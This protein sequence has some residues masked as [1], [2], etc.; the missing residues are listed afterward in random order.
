MPFVIRAR[1]VAQPALRPARCVALAFLVACDATTVL[2]PDDIPADARIVA[3][4]PAST[5]APSGPWSDERPTIRMRT[6]AGAAVANRLVE[7]K[8]VGPDGAFRTFAVRTDSAGRGMLPSI[9]LDSVGAWRVEVRAGMA[10]PLQFGVIA[11][12]RALMATARAA[13]CPLAPDQLP[14]FA[15]LPRSAALLRA[16]RP[17]RIVALGT[18]S[19]SGYGLDNWSNAYPYAF[20]EQLRAVF[21][22]SDVLLWNRGSAGYA[23]ERIDSRLEID[24]FSVN[25]DL[26]LLQTGMMDAI[27]GVPLN[28]LRTVTERTIDR[29]Q[30][31]GIDVVLIDQQRTPGTGE[32]E[33]YLRYVDLIGRI[34]EE[35]GLPLVRRYEWMSAMLARGVYR[36]SDMMVSD[37]VHHSVLGHECIAHLLTVGMTT[38]TVTAPR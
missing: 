32:S 25:P 19:T 17:I 36:Y 21:P 15:G 12:P 16:G 30:A 28:V 33:N 9:D 29:L 4:T 8:V 5:F 26:V 11:L 18:S 1:H 20:R 34:A 6:A 22:R 23:A 31:R 3:E 7:F 24:A 13:R 2:A 37:L 10:V 35:R 27:W 38:A 14:R